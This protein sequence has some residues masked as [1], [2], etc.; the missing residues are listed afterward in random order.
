MIFFMYVGPA[1]KPIFFN[2]A[3]LK[4]CLEARQICDTISFKQ[5]YD[6]FFARKL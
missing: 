1:H 3:T 2:K 6:I 4:D 5:F